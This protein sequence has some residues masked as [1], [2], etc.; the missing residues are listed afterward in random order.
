VIV[1]DGDRMTER[2]SNV[3][4]K[5]IEEPPPRTVWVL[6]APSPRD[7]I[8][9]IRSRCRPITLRI[10]SVEA[11]AALLEQTDHVEPDVARWA[12]Q[13]AQCHIGIAR[14]LATDPDARA[15]RERVLAIPARATSV[16]GAVIAAGELVEAAKAEAERVGQAQEAA[17]KSELHRAYGVAE[18]EKA[19]P[20]VRGQIDQALKGSP[21]D[22]KRRATRFQRDVLDRALLD[23][24]SFYRDVLSAQ[25][26]S[27]VDLVNSTHADEIARTGE[28]TDAATTLRRIEVIGEARERLAGNVAPALAIEAMAVGLALAG[29]S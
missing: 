4:L 11:V 16:G 3:L 10:P 7:V 1:E 15:Q 21:Q 8:V 5:A 6:T 2:T 25:E 14:R 18:D 27:G 12:A 13:A 9:T 22:A 19:A 20:V 24:L 29:D 26:R 23:L 17:R 28:T